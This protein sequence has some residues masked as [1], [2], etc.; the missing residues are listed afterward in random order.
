MPF[1]P[2]ES[3]DVAWNVSILRTNLHTFSCFPFFANTVTAPSA[4]ANP[5]DPSRIEGGGGAA[6]PPSMLAMLPVLEAH[7]IMTEGKSVV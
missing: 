3:A 4:S 7:T 1:G 5:P 6:R 2:A